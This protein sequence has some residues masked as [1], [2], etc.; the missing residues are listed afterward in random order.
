MQE[1]QETR[2]QSPKKKKKK[3]RIQSPGGVDPLEEEM[4]TDSSILAGTNPW[5]EE[6]GAP[7]ATEHTHW[8]HRGVHSL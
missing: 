3:K 8:N 4:A 2:I 1:I 5:T 7:G 6:P